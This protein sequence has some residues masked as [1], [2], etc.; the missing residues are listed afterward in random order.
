[1]RNAERAMEWLIRAKS[2]LACAKTG[3]VFQDILYDS[4]SE[5]V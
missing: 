3:K 4:T 5:R 2:N 1:M